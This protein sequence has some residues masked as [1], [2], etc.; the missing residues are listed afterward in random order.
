MGF[1]PC[2]LTNPRCRIGGLFSLLGPK[3]RIAGR[4][5]PPEK[6]IASFIS[7]PERAC[8]Y[9]VYCFHLLNSLSCKKQKHDIDATA[10]SPKNA[11]KTAATPQNQVGKVLLTLA[12][13]LVNLYFWPEIADLYDASGSTSCREQ[14]LLYGFWAVFS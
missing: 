5:K 12:S 11:A 6:I 3:E 4:R 2:R 13:I 14:M 10:K 9:S 8:V 7:S 1:S